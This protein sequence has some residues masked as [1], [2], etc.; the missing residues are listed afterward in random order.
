MKIRWELRGVLTGLALVAVLG[1]I[2][3]SVSFDVP[4]QRLL[5]TLRFHIAAT[6]LLIAVGLALVGG[7][8]RAGVVMIF[9]LA[10]AGEGAL[11]IRDQQALRESLEQLPVAASVDV[12]SFN[13]LNSNPNG[14]AIAERVLDLAP[15]IAIIMESAPVRSVAA[16]D[17]AYPHRAGC[18]E[19]GTACDLLVYSKTPFASNRVLPLGEFRRL[20]LVIAETVI[21]GVGVT[22][23]GLHLTKPYF[24]DLMLAEL[25]QAFRALRELEGPVILAGDFNAAAW[26]DDIAEL[27]ERAALVPPPSYPATWPVELADIGVPIDNLFTRGNALITAIN[28]MPDAMGSNHRGLVAS[29]AILGAP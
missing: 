12:L 9:A 3:V 11:I 17:Q 7:W 1:I 22:I 15:D 10:S 28:A 5:Q 23:V 27:A 8:K 16:M 2:L 4:G 21:E 25:W 29:V 6:T 26:S 24:D 13:V 19:E 20:R 18:S 14:V